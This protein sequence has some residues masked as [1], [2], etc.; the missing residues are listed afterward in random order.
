MGEMRNT[1]RIL[2]KFLRLRCRWKFDI[3]VG[4]GEVG[5]IQLAQKL[6][7]VNFF[8]NMNLEGP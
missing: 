2:V 7:P 5:W 3:K 6:N 8:V 1:Y 4:H